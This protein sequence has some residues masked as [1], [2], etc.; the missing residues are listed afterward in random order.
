V[1][2]RAATYPVALD[3]T[4]CR[5]GLRCYHVSRGPRPCLPTEVGSGATTCPAAPYLTS[6]LRW[7]PTL[8]CVPQLRSSLPCRGGLRH[9]HLSH[10]SG[11]F[12]PKGRAPMLP[13]VPRPQWAVDHRNK[14]R[15][16]CPRHATRL[17]CFRG[18][19]VHYQGKTSSCTCE[20]ASRLCV[21]FAGLMTNN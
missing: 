14:E 21:D 12:L 6:L 20:S 16:S 2:P 17:A 7:A 10:G 1:H 19:Y 4:P 3:L 9:F 15:L 11:I 18:K 8:P 5:G 13:C